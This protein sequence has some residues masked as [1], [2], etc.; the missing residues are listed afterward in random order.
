MFIHKQ[1]ELKRGHMR[2]QSKK[3]LLSGWFSDV[4]WM[5]ANAGFAPPFLAPFT[6][7][8]KEPLLHQKS[9]A[10][11]PGFRSLNDKSAAI[12]TAGRHLH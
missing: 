8:P 1:S 4:P 9:P 10:D 2:K 6:G 11:W 3:G 5:P 12:L 7:L